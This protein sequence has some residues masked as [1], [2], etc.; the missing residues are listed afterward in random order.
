M[1]IEI[2]GMSWGGLN[3]R[4]VIVVFGVALIT[5]IPISAHN[6]AFAET[7]PITKKME[8]MYFARLDRWVANGADFETIQK[9]VIENC[10][11]LVMISATKAEMVSFMTTQKEEFHFRVDVCAKTT[12]NRAHPQPELKNPKTV[13]MI[14][15]SNT[16]FFRKLCKRS[17]LQ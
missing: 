17:N 13:K 4:K 10:G 2:C 14:C 12:V 16:G 11:K 1:P 8:K 5:A 3:I 9:D 15:E 6:L 7:S